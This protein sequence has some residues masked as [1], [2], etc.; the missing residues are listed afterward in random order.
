MD[1]TLLKYPIVTEKSTALGQDGKYV[2]KVSKNA[3][4]SEIKKIVESV[5]NVKVVKANSL[6]TKDKSR[7]LGNSVGV[8]P[9]Y[10]KVI[11]TLQKGQK[12]DIISQ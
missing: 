5:Y 12:L 3:S 9:G 1:K 11:V 7:R 2:F 6:N 4:V 10:K 8:R